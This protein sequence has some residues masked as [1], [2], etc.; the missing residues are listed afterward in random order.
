MNERHDSDFVVERQN[1][2][3][4]S[5][6]GVKLREGESPVLNARISAGIYWKA[7]AVVLLSF[8]IGLIAWQLGVFLLCVAIITASTG[9]LTKKFLFL[10]LT[11]QRVLMRRGIIKVDTMQL[12]LESLESVEVQRTLVGQFLGYASVV[13]TGVG[14]RFTLVP[15]VANAVE[16]R[17]ALDDALYKKE[18]PSDSKE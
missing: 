13:I 2:K 14:T 6:N 4:K 11:N 12:R 9:F 16:F 1:K 5:F 8:L 17:D 10:A 3:R 18:K 15:F 7:C